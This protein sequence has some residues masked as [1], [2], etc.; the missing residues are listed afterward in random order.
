LLALAKEQRVSLAFRAAE[1][2]S[3]NDLWQRAS[4]VQSDTWQMV[5]YYKET[6][7]TAGTL[8]VVAAGPGVQ[9]VFV[10]PLG[11]FS[12]VLEKGDFARF[13]AKLRQLGDFLSSGKKANEPF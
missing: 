4:Q 8:L 6:N 7:T 1:W 12:F 3:I 11:T 13:G 10:D 9:F 5:G 2:N